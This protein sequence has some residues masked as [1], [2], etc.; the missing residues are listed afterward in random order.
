MLHVGEHCIDVFYQ[1]KGV[2][3]HPRAMGQGGHTT[4][5][6]HMPKAHAKHQEWTPDRFL[7]WASQV[8]A[9]TERVV[10]YQ[11][12]NR[13]IQNMVI[14]LVWAFLTLPRNTARRV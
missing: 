1:G 10:R 14:V 3:Q 13:P 2:A 5:V 8:G 6:A 12:E 4:H 11:L 9:A 7:N